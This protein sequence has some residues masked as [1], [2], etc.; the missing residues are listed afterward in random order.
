MVRHRRPE[1]LWVLTA[2]E[3]DISPDISAFLMISSGP[4]NI[5]LPL[6]SISPLC[7]FWLI[8]FPVCAKSAY[9]NKHVLTRLQI[10]DSKPPTTSEALIQLVFFAITFLKVPIL[11]NVD[12]PKL[13]MAPNRRGSRIVSE[14]QLTG[15]RMKGN[16]L[17]A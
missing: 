1:E 11:V 12:L 17:K 16:S 2:A 4:R 5:L 3:P 10:C 7:G 14:I 6:Q 15:E 13:A 9:G 8:Y